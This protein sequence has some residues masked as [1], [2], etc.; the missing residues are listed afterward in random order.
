MFQILHCYQKF[1]N[2]LMHYYLENSLILMTLHTVWG[3]FYLT[4]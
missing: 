1:K 3:T 4:I 2:I